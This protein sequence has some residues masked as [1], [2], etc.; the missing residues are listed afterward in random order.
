[1]EFDAFFDHA[2]RTPLAPYGAALRSALAQV[3]P[4]KHGDFARWQQ[5]VLDLPRV[6]I[7]SL[8]LDQAVVRAGAAGDVDEPT[9]ARIEHSLRGLHPWRKG[10]FEVCGVHI[11]TEWRSDWK[12]DR[13]APHIDDLHGRMVLDIGCGSGYHLW[14]MRGAG[15][16]L[17]LGV[18]PSLLFQM[19][20]RALQH[21]IGQQPV[22]HLPLGIEHLPAEMRAF[23]TVFSMGVLYH[24]RSPF[25]HLIELR[26]LLRPGGQLVLETLVIDGE[27]G[28]VLVPDGRYARMGNVWFLPSVPT[29]LQWLRKVRFKNARCVDVTVTTAQEQRPTDWMTFQSL[30]DFLDAQDATRTIEGYPGPKRALVL[31]EV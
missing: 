17:T 16:A 1:M 31:A 15:A 10:P 27:E 13:L 6:A 25:D 22:Y 14:R 29:L 12:W 18:D 28:Q 9:R 26:D 30:P 8:A 24:R 3:E 21:F 11:D 5:A 4:D 2:A 20:F 23:D 19:Q 7:S